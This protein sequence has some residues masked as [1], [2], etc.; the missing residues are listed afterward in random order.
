VASDPIPDRLA[1][2]DAAELLGVSTATARQ[3]VDRGLLGPTRADGR[4]ARVDVLAYQR[5]RQERLAA[6]AA[7]TEADQ[8]SGLPY[9]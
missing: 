5:R 3:L 1:V 9:R 8:A 2:A 4:V 7:I 6:V